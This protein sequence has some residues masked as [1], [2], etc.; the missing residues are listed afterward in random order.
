MPCACWSSKA[1]LVGDQISILPVHFD[2]QITLC[3]GGPRESVIKYALAWRQPHGMDRRYTGPNRGSWMKDRQ[4]EDSELKRT[5]FTP[6]DLRSTKAGML[7]NCLIILIKGADASTSSHD[8]QRSGHFRVVF[9]GHGWEHD[10]GM[11]VL[12]FSNK[13]YTA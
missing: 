1:S 5:L 7:R 9:N 6:N 2:L 13:N 8:I 12:H 11:V 4:E 3:R 10:R